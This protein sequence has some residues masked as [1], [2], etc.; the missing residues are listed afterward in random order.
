MHPSEIDDIMKTFTL[1]ID[2]RE[3]QTERSKIRYKQFDCPYRREKLDFGDY[4]AVVYLPDGKPYQIPVKIE[5]KMNLDEACNCFTHDRPR[6]E[7]EF[8][9]AR[10]SGEKLVIL[11][12]NASW[13]IAYAGKYR[14]KMAPKALVASMLSWLARYDCQILMCKSESSGKLIKDLLWREAKIALERMVDE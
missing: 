6:F 5:R 7:R 9:R 13:E 4:G 3:Q 10:E 14:S 2:S 11:I 12:E 1:Q 8:E